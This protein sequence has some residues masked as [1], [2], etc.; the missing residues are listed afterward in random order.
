M[1]ALFLTQ[2]E[3]ERE[4]KTKKNPPETKTKTGDRD[5]TSET[6]KGDRIRHVKD[7][8]NK[9]KKQRPSRRQPK[10]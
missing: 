2:I 1:C 3:R 8:R 10:H 4:K 5:P 7:S 9:G 6:K